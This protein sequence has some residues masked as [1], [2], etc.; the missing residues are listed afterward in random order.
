MDRTFH[1]SSLSA[2]ELPMHHPFSMSDAAAYRIWRDQKLANYPLSLGEVMVTVADARNL[3][4]EELKL[5]HRALQR[6]NFVVY[7]STRPLDKS[8]VTLLAGQ[9]GLAHL[10][11]HE[12]TDND[13]I[14]SIQANA[15]DAD[16]GYIP[17]SNR[18]LNW[19]TDGYYNPQTAPIRTFIL[20]CV[21]PS[22]SG[23]EN[24]LLDHQLA[25]VLLREDNPDYIRALMHPEAMTIPANKRTGAVTRG[26]STGPVFSVLNDGELHMRYTART[27]SI[28]WRDD[29]LLTE[30]RRA[31]YNIIIESDLVLTHKLQAGQGLICRNILHARTAFKDSPEGGRLVYRAR[32]Y[33][34][35]ELSGMEAGF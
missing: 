27:R 1:T 14:S 19:H 7:E 34:A 18:E 3:S 33:D 24:K 22:A 16:P 25:Y 17:Y 13:G 15:D 20:H 32:Y 10:D 30:A 35:V 29:P 23:G 8:G 4:P 11:R 26:D 28:V 2:L 9:L 21:R 5:L 12:C 6:A 31:L